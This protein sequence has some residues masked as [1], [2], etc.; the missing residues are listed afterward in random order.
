[1]DLSIKLVLDQEKLYFDIEKYKKLV[2]KLNYL[3]ATSLDISFA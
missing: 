3:S 1:M 2:S